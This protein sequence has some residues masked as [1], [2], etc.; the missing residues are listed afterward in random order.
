[1]TTLTCHWLGEVP[2]ADALR[3]QS[4]LRQRV[5]DNDS[6]GYLLLLTHPPTFTVGR[7]GQM[8][9]VLASGGLLDQRGVTVHQVDRG[10]DVT[11]H[12]PGQLVGYPILDLRKIKRGVR[13]YVCGLSRALTATAAEYGVETVWDEKAP[14]LWV[15]NNK[16]AAFGVHVSRHVTT[17]GFAFN[18][19]PDMSFYQMIVPC[20]LAQRGVTSLKKLLRDRCPSMQDVVAQVKSAMIEELGL[21]LEYTALDFVVEGA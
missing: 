18:V 11:Y 17:H 9:N 12:G 2:Y 8:A 15:G 21:N 16:L 13:D 14:G 6:N 3:I 7:H 20:G 10:G 1:M 5:I 4:Q 19:A